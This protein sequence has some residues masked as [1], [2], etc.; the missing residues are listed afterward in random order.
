MALGRAIDSESFAR[1]GIP[2]SL[3]IGLAFT[4][5][6]LTISRQGFEGTVEKFIV[7]FATLFGISAIAFFGFLVQL[8]LF[9]GMIY[10]VLGRIGR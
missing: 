2:I 10:L 4:I 3:G 9:M 8:L 7:S 5:T 6:F 1:I